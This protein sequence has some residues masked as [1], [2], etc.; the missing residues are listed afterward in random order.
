MSFVFHWLIR[1]CPAGWAC[2][3]TSLRICI[4]SVLDV[5]Q[6][7]RTLIKNRSFLNS[8]QQ[9]HSHGRTPSPFPGCLL[10]MVCFRVLFCLMIQRHRLILKITNYV[11]L[12]LLDD[13][14]LERRPRRENFHRFP[15]RAMLWKVN[16][17]SVR[18]LIVR[19]HVCK[20]GKL[21]RFS[22]SAYRD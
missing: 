12:F 15:R 13:Q 22:L 1:R 14:K 16:R 20:K 3:S 4:S 5:D 17:E 8:I 19:V 6:A 11:R 18:T 7:C 9:A 2:R 10:F 21:S